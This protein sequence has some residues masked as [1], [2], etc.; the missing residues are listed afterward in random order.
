ME[1]L[2]KHIEK[3]NQQGG[4]D[5]EINDYKQQIADL[6]NQLHDKPIEVTQTVE[7]IP[8]EVAEAIYCKIKYL[9]E[10]IMNLTDKEIRIFA[11]HVGPDYHD[12]LSTN[13]GEAV[14]TLEKIISTVWEATPCEQYYQSCAPSAETVLVGERLSWRGGGGGGGNEN[15]K[16]MGDA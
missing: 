3:L 6:Q 8:D 2:K 9:Y 5:A 13:I 10:S 12:T 7:V 15:R 11:D 16:N 14:Q 1:E 4:S